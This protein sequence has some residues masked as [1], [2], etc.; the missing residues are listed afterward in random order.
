MSLIV[1]P[2]ALCDVEQ[3]I[4]PRSQDRCCR[5]CWRHYLRQAESLKLSRR[6]EGS[7]RTGR[8]LAPTS[9]PAPHADL[10]CPA[11]VTNARLVP[12]RDM[13]QLWEM[14][15]CDLLQCSPEHY[16]RRPS[17]WRPPRQRPSRSSTRSSS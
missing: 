13:V 12:K 8:V 6:S 14:P 1:P 15:R 7:D 17:V 16:W 10:T 11:P 3:G 4:A 9:P 2:L 5:L